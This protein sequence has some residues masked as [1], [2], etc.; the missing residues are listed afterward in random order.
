M[1]LCWTLAGARVSYVVLLTGA[2]CPRQT[3]HDTQWVRQ[4]Q[5]K[6]TVHSYDCSAMSSSSVRH[7]ARVVQ[8]QMLG[9]PRAYCALC[10]LQ[11]LTKGGRACSTH[12]CLSPRCACLRRQLHPCSTAS[13]PG[14]ERPAAKPFC[15]RSRTYIIPSFFESAASI[16]ST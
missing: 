7:H 6:H 15:A 13:P 5:H 14:V 1:C 16:L 2:C 4:A 3:Y 8:S 10:L 11:T 12:V 9:R